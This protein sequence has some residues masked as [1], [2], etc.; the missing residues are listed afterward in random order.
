MLT[1]RS[2]EGTAWPRLNCLVI[3]ASDA[4]TNGYREKPAKSRESVPA[5]SLRIGTGLGR[6]RGLRGND[7]PWDE[8]GSMLTIDAQL[9]FFRYARYAALILTR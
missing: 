3:V 8:Y 6:L 9:N 4:D 2:V 5:V 1:A 7:N